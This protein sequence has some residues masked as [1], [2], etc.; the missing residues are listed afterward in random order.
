MFTT[1]GFSRLFI[2]LLFRTLSFGSCKEE[3]YQLLA[4]LVRLSLVSPSRDLWSLFVP[5]QCPFHPEAIPFLSAFL[6]HHQLPE[7]YQPPVM[8]CVHQAYEGNHPLRL[9]LI[10]WLLPNQKDASD[11]SPQIIINTPSAELAHLLLC[12]CM[13]DTMGATSSYASTALHPLEDIFLK[14]SFIIPVYDSLKQEKKAS[15]SERI[16]SCLTGVYDKMIS[17]IVQQTRLVLE[18]PKEVCSTSYGF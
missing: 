6:H 17:A 14:N 12:L 2:I 10:D 13:R 8:G 11:C 18:Q 7:D 15:T 3:A 16:S 5:S 1:H 9:Q 4:S